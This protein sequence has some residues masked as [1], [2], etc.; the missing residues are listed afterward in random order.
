MP[1]DLRWSCII[2]IEIKCTIKVICL[3]Q[4]QTIPLLPGSLKNCLPQH[5]SLVPK[6]LGTTHSATSPSKLL[7]PAVWSASCP[8][9]TWG[10]WPIT[11]KHTWSHTSF[12]KG[13]WR[14]IFFLFTRTLPL[15]SGP[16]PVN[17][18]TDGAWKPHVTHLALTVSFLCY[19]TL[20]HRLSNISIYQNH[21]KGLL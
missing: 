12:G 15:L 7:A 4:P 18:Y 13:N 21:L 8:G 2:I 19:Y 6:R 16:N 3:N 5:W 14:P 17:S 10:F 11:P 9:T 20:I 1:G